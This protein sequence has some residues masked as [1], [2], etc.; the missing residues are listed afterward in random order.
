MGTRLVTPPKDI[1][2]FPL[3]PAGGGILTEENGSVYEGEFHDNKRHGEGVQIYALVDI[4]IAICAGNRSC[5]LQM[6]R[7][8]LVLRPSHPHVCCFHPGYKARSGIPF[9]IMEKWVGL[10]Q[11]GQ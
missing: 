4:T 6:K 7:D 3:D 2:S 9:S 8:S 1:V 11:T 5:D 10:S